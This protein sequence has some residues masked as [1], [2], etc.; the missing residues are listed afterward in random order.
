MTSSDGWFKVRKTD[1]P[2][3]DVR[4]IACGSNHVVSS[5]VRVADPDPSSSDVY[6]PPGQPVYLQA[7]GRGNNQTDTWDGV[8]SY[9]N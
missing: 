2:A 6:V 4:F 3:I 7:L 5:I 1:G 8:V 9:Y